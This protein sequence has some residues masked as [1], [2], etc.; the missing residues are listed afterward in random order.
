VLLEFFEIT[1]EILCLQ[2]LL[3]FP[4]SSFEFTL[5]HLYPFP[6][7]EEWIKSLLYPSLEYFVI[8]IWWSECFTHPCFSGMLI[9]PIIITEMRKWLIFTVYVGTY[10]SINKNHYTYILVFVTSS[11]YFRRNRSLSGINENYSENYKRAISMVP[12]V[13]YT[14]TCKLRQTCAMTI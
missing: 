13:H 1:R 3:W 12:G 9:Y 2:L 14:H 6:F 8:C 10:H 11:T 5:S 4:Y 7:L